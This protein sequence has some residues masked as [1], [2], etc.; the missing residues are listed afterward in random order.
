MEIMK[1]AN[2][3]ADKNIFPV[4]GRGISYSYL[5]NSRTCRGRFYESGHNK[6]DNKYTCKRNFKD[7]EMYLLYDCPNVQEY[8][9][10]WTPCYFCEQSLMDWKEDTNHGGTVTIHVGKMY[11]WGNKR[12]TPECLALMIRQGFDLV[13]WDWSTFQRQMRFSDRSACQ[14]LLD[15]IQMCDEF[16]DAYTAIERVINDAQ[17]LANRH[18]TRELDGMCRL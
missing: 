1:I 16:D 12:S 4:H 2:S 5:P 15:L 9:S 18:S 8:W 14:N 10:G 11:N 7:S 3:I 6:C 13:P 17:D